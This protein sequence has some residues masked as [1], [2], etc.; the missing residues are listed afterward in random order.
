MCDKLVA[1]VN[2]IDTIGS[3]LKT[4]YKTDKSDLEKKDHDTSRLVKKLDYNAKITEIEIETPSISGLATNASSTAVENKTLDVSSSVKKT[5]YDTKTCEFEKTLTDHNYD[6]YITI[7]EFI[8]L[9]E[10]VFDERLK[11]A[12]VVTK[13]DFDDKRKNQ[14]QKI[15]SNK[16]KNLLFENELKKLQPFD[17]IC[18]R[19]KSH[20]E[21]DVTQ[22]YLVFHPM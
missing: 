14:N 11:Q 13:A 2:N 20:F 15:N 1:K 4:K 7:P 3:V 5:D 17:S 16:T 10:E 18:F 9:S 12:N 22:S 8:K 21:K 19:D 6:E